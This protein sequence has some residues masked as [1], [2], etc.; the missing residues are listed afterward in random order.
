MTMAQFLHDHS[1]EIALLAVLFL[2]VAAV[3]IFHDDD[4][5][6]AL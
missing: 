1:W 2:A 5:D 3:A 4:W 6:D